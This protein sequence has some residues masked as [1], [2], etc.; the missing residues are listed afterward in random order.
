MKTF[1][2]KRNPD[3]SPHEA[4]Q[5]CLTANLAVPG[6]G[7]VLVGRKVGFV[8]MAIYFSGFA[9][10]LTFGL[11]LI[12]WVLSHWSAFYAEF[13]SPGADVLAAMSDL[14]HRIRWALLGIGLFLISW[15]WALST[16]RT[17]LAEANSKKDIPKPAP[18]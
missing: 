1:L 8:Q 14:W 15:I 5:G 4:A 17:V 10:T 7:S 12:Y 11:R 3:L 6:L 2:A 18:L 16:S 9:L 13:Y